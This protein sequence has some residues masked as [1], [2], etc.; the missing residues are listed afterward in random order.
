MTAFDDAELAEPRAGA[1][2]R[3]PDPSKEQAI[4]DAAQA[5]FLEKGY[6]ASVDE[7]AERAGVVKQTVYSRFRSKEDLFAACV[8]AAAWRV[9]RHAA[10][11]PG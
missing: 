11:R 8:R 7:I 1:R 2:G 10:G 5:L 6:G 9:G 4:L 3:R